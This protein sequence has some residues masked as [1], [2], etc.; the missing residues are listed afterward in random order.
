M[1]RRKGRRL[2]FM[3]PAQNL[4]IELIYN[5][6]SLPMSPLFLTMLPPTLLCAHLLVLIFLS[7]AR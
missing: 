3:A 6:R 5:A 1:V 7:T 4:K 2:R